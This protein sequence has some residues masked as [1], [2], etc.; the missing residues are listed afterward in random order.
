M[1]E[2]LIGDQIVVL[3]RAIVWARVFRDVPVAEDVCTGVWV[4][5]AVAMGV[6]GLYPRERS[7]VSINFGPYC[8][9][10]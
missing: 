4:V 10:V 3:A 1:I 7:C 8:V 6:T 9:V 5:V 2:S